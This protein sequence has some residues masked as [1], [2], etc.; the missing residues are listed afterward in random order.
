MNGARCTFPIV[1]RGIGQRAFVR[2]I[3]FDCDDGGD[4]LRFT[5]YGYSC[6]EKPLFDTEWAARARRS[7]KFAKC[8]FICQRP[9]K[10]PA[11][12]PWT[13][14][15]DA[16]TTRDL[17]LLAALSLFCAISAWAGDRAVFGSAFFALGAFAMLGA[18]YRRR[19]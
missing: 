3:A 15:M 16:K 19:R 14:E 17:A 8:K 7:L 13:G 4:H 12:L 2:F 1:Q 10:Q 6:N 9:E 18:A 11:A 5:G